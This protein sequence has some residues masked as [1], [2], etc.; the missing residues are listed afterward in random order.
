M[1][2]LNFKCATMNSGK[3]LDLIR[4][5]YNYEENEFNVLILKP[6]VDTKAN[7]FISSRVG[8][9]RKVDFLIHEDDDIFELLKGSLKDVACILIDEAQF[10]KEYQVDQFAIITKALDI[11]VICFG[12]RTNFMMKSFEGSKRLLEIAEEIEIL[13]TMCR[14][15]NVARFVGRK[16]NGEFVTNGKEIVIDGTDN[17]EY[18]PLCGDCYFR[19]VKKI[20]YQ[21]IKQK[22]R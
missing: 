13:P 1:A 3:T 22:L 14:C 7:N 21:K 11:P 19:Q 8:L 15:G 16:E 10:L 4:T 9:K 12:L 17:V 20:D 5:A 6:A 2:K 18:V